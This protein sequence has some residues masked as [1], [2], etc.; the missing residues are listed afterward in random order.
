MTTTDYSLLAASAATILTVAA[1]W[2]R[3]ASETARIY[4]TELGW[5]FGS[6]CAAMYAWLVLTEERPFSVSTTGLFALCAIWIGALLPIVTR[7]STAR[8]EAAARRSAARMNRAA[9]PRSPGAP[10]VPRSRGDGPKFR[11]AFTDGHPFPALAGM[12]L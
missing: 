4:V 12:G 3:R 10:G 8:E 6:F 7:R 1:Y 2:W 11:V 9:C 5:S